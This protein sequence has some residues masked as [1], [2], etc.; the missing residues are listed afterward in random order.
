MLIGAHKM[1]RMALNFLG[2]YLKDGSEFL[3]HV[4]QVTGDET[5]LSF[6]NVETKEQSK[7]W[8]HTHSPDK[9]K[10]FKHSLRTRKLILGQERSADGDIHAPRTTVSEAYCRTLKKLRRAGHSEQKAFNADIQCSAPPWLCVRIRL[11]TLDY[12]WSI[13]TG[14]CLP[15]WRT[16][17][18]HST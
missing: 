4:V 13:S 10:E 5:W 9:Q 18:D 1:Q 17:W 3:S 6:M 16:G 8:M 15:T 11:L 14:N 7:Q 2:W 12:F